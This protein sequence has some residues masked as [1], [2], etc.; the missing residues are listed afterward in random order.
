MSTVIN[1]Q[2][3]TEQVSEMKD[4]GY[5]L[6]LAKKVGDKYTVIWQTKTP[7][8]TNTYFPNNRLELD[9]SGYIVN[10][11]TSEIKVGDVSYTGAGVDKYMDLGT[12]TRL[13]KN[14]IFGDATGGTDKQS[15]VIESDIAGFPSEILK[16]AKGNVLFVNVGHGLPP[17]GKSIITPL[18][19]YQLWFSSE[20]RMGDIIV[21]NTTSTF[22]VTLEESKTKKISYTADG[23][24]QMGPLVV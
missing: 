16:D 24:W 2:I 23:I 6:C 5:S 8:G 17:H 22:E 7:T 19:S 13:S 3:H 15:I 20:Q 10:Y 18:H 14:G 4:N 9:T 21:Q 12:V 11:C 1:L